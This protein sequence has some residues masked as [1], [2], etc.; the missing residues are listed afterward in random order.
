MKTKI[1]KSLDSNTRSICID[2]NIIVY[3]LKAD[4]VEDYLTYNDRL[5]EVLKQDRLKPFRDEGRLRFKVH[6][7]KTDI[8]FY[9]YDV[10]Y[11]C[12]TSVV[13]AENWLNDMQRYYE[14]KNSQGLVID[15]ADSN[16]HNNTV[17][18]LSLI[19]RVLNSI[20]SD[21]VARVKL[22]RDLNSIYHNGVYRVQMM[23][24]AKPSIINDYLFREGIKYRVS[25]DSCRAA[26]R[27]LC[28][29]PED[30]VGCLRWLTEQGL[31][32]AEPIKDIRGN[33]IKNDRRCWCS[34]IKNSL[35]AQ[36]VLSEMSLRNFNVFNREKK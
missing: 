30:Y 7:N 20:K 3:K 35:Y 29:T 22:P 36:R 14:S 8:N 25:D 6:E 4:G 34:N 12:Y 11:A 5:L 33:W 32:W 10:A 16:I 17:L 19:P 2:G 13:R 24:E 21:I 9:L 15:H 31:E 28:E 27:F 26:I 1:T 18:N 23:T